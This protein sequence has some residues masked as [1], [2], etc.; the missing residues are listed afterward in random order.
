MIRPEPSSSLCANK[1]CSKGR[2]ACCISTDCC[3]RV[4]ATFNRPTMEHRRRSSRSLRDKNR[5]WVAKIRISDLLIVLCLKTCPQGLAN[6]HI[7]RFCSR[8]SLQI[9]TDRTVSIL[10]P[11]Q[12]RTAPS[13]QS[14]KQVCSPLQQVLSRARHRLIR[15]LAGHRR[16]P[17]LQLARTAPA[18]AGIR[19]R[20]VGVASTERSHVTVTARRR[21]A[22]S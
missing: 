21:R 4:P 10:S 11:K 20:R 19:R 13:D 1:R 15:R 3:I 6:F 14:A 2:L 7:S 17:L 22:N 16:Q 5:I 9:A 12:A 8:G 18:R